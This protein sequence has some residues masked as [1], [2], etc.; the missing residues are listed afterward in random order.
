[1]KRRQFIMLLGG[2]AVAW[3]LAAHA[4]KKRGGPIASV[5]LMPRDDLWAIAFFDERAVVS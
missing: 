3:P 1:M 2:G 5:A 4:R